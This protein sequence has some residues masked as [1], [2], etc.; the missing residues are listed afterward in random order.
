M[1]L[2]CMNFKIYKMLLFEDQIL[3]MVSKVH[4]GFIYFIFSWSQAYTVVE[5][6]WLHTLEQMYT[7][8]FTSGMVKFAFFVKNSILFTQSNSVNNNAVVQAISIFLKNKEI[9]R[10][11]YCLFSRWF[12]S[13]IVLLQK[14][15][16]LVN[17]LETICWA[18][19]ILF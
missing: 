2:S 5:I 13:N 10:K 6:R 17:A 16:N 4:P 1:C 19:F 9:F 18:K 11:E 15:K 3:P 7:I 8:F 12:L 14:N